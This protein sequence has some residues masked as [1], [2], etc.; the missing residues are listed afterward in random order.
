[1]LAKNKCA[2]PSNNA[3]P[4]KGSLP[5]AIPINAD[6]YL[7]MPAKHTPI[8]VLLHSPPRLTEPSIAAI[9]HAGIGVPTLSLSTK[10]SLSDSGIA[11]MLVL[12]SRL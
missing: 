3:M 9:H 6:R 2:V 12:H 7:Q 8:T 10:Q 5:N 1:M 11:L 4:F